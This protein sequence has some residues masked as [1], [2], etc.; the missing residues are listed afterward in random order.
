MIDQVCEK[1]AKWVLTIYSKENTGYSSLKL[2]NTSADETI[3]VLLEGV[4]D[5]ET[6]LFQ[7]LFALKASLSLSVKSSNRLE[8]R[9]CE[10]Y[11][12]GTKEIMECFQSRQRTLS[13]ILNSAKH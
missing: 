10:E 9:T 8:V 1:W 2:I 5:S 12:E 11:D 3:G 7:M 4:V 6:H 13:K